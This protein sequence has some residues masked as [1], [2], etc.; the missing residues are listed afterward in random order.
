[1]NE[2]DTTIWETL[3]DNSEPAATSEPAAI[4]GFH[5]FMIWVL[6]LIRNR[7]T[8]TIRFRIKRRSCFG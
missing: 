8:L 5:F 7:I 4:S 2:Y 3:E 1:M 6:T